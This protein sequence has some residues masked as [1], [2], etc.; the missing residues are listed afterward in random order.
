[1]NLSKTSSK[2]VRAG[3][4]LAVPALLLTAACG[5]DKGSDDSDKGAG[6]AVS[7]VTGAFGAKPKV[8]APKNAKAPKDVAVKTVIQGKGEKAVK[9][10][11][12]R[13]DFAGQVLKNGR[14]LG[15][16]WST[17]KATKGPHQQ[18][19]A[20]LGE[21]NQSLPP[22]VLD[23][24][25]GAKAGSRVLVEGGAQ[26][27]NAKAEAQGTQAA[28]KGGLPK[29]E[30]PKQ[31][32]AAITIPKGQKAPTALKDQVL[33]QGKGKEIAAGQGLIAQ[34]TGVK[35]DDG[36]QFASSWKH[37]GATPF[38]IGTG[39][40][41]KGWDQALVGKHVGDRVLMVIPPKLAYGNK[42]QQGNDLGG[43]TLVFVVDIVGAV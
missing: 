1:M 38:Q 10:D 25:V 26:K 2:T 41:V 3:V 35:W 12:V 7:K 27:V 11:T 22:K 33:I 30:V 14:D 5:S 16:T 21:Q 43:K 36:K 15:S 37:A 29:V 17:A 18:I 32:A 6:A 9:G 19:V 40:V 39:S 4:A 13:L 8:T 20:K 23:A 42:K 34:Y 28:V 31:K 24:V